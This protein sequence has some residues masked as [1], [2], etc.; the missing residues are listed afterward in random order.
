MEKAFVLITCDQGKEKEIL[1]N[2]HKTDSIKACGTY[3]S[4][5]ILA[6]VMA[7]TGQ[8]LR[9]I[10][11]LNIRTIPSITSTMTLTTTCKGP[12]E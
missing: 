3:G 4:Y 11:T 9:E 1:S 12:E 5:D 7:E 10:I 2:L 8:S 6:E